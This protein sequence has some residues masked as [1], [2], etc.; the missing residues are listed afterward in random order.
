VTEVVE[1]SAGE[2]VAVASAPGT[3]EATAAGGEGAAAASSHEVLRVGRFDY[4]WVALFVVLGGSIM[5]ILDATIVNVAVATLQREFHVASYSDIAWVVTGYMLAQGAVIPMAGWMTDR[6]GTKRVYLVTLVLFTAASAACGAAWNLP[7]LIVFRVLQGIGGGM[8]MP[9]GMTIILRAFGP[10]QMGRVMGYF[11]VPTLLAP[12]AGP[13]LG[14][15]LVQDFSWRLIFYV[16]VPVGAVAILVAW[17]FL[18]ETPHER[19]LKLDVL[20]LL[21]A[22]PAVMAL[23]YGVDR[24]TELGW[25]S[26]LVIG[27][28]IASAVL[29]TV[30]VRH[31]LRTDEPLLHLRLFKDPTFSWSVVLSLFV[32]TSLFGVVYL[33][34][35]FLQQVR[36]Y[37]A[38]TT[39]LLLMPQAATAAIF[40]P[41]SGLLAD[42][43]GPRYVVGFGLVMLAI[44]SVML[45]QLHTDTSITYIVLVMMLRGLAM[46]FTMMPAMAAGLARIPRESASR[47]SSITNTVQRAGSSVAIA[48]LVTVLAGQTG[49]AAHQATCDPSP[50]VLAAAPQA[51]LPTDR[52]Q[53]CAALADRASA[54]SRDQQ[55]LTPGVT[56]PQLAA[57][58]AEYRKEVGAISFDRLFAL[59]A[60]LCVLGIFPAWQL[61]RPEGGLRGT[62]VAAA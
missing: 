58:L 54:F 1:T 10:A 8:L 12:A 30:F 52:A 46:G 19:K 35:L 20:G 15:W 60:V 47:A 3:A 42:R 7:A 2:R 55:A 24:T 32:V 43:F 25:G 57:F 27:L 36:G 40:M 31:Q 26:P 34:P 45:A 5:T 13:V 16:N 62:A 44:S 50:A 6:Y 22:I 37:D 17:R 23:M 49:V 28:L 51:N 39:G 59:I 56:D 53:F 9:I 21:T 33:L 41:V 14:G 4:R 38:I 18:R 29:F 61:R 48:V 11:G